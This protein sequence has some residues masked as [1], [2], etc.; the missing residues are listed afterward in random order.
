MDTTLPGAGFYRR[1]VVFGSMNWWSVEDLRA[2]IRWVSGRTA[3]D[4]ESTSNNRVKSGYAHRAR[5]PI[6]RVPDAGSKVVS[7]SQVSLTAGFAE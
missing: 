3:N 4:R 2:E 7:D 6:D 5:P 1:H